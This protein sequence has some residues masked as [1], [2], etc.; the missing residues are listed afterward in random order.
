MAPHYDD[1]NATFDSG[2]RYDSPDNPPVPSVSTK[3]RRMRN[4]I[5]LALSHLSIPDGIAYLRKIV[6]KTKGNAAF[7]TIAAKTTALETAVQKTEDDNTAFNAAQKTADTLMTVRDSSVL[8]MNTL[9]QDLATAAEGVTKDPATL[10]SGGW[11]L[12]ATHASPVGP[13]L[14]PSNFHATSGD[15]LG[16]VDLMCDTQKGVQSHMAESADSPD[17]PF[18]VCYVGRKSSCAVKGFVSGAQKWFRMCAVGAAGPGPWAGPIS[19]R[20]T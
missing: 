2:L 11:D 8:S 18:T 7:T 16:E 6:A 1:P 19:K 20:A 12:V 10:E 17:G 4:I 14:M 15:N 13:M 5:K 9:A 3:G